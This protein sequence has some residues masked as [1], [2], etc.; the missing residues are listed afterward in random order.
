MSKASPA[1]QAVAP[2]IVLSRDG[3]LAFVKNS[4]CACT[5]ITKAIHHYDT[6]AQFDG[7][8]HR[9][10]KHLRQGYRSWNDIRDALQSNQPYVFSFVRDPEARAVSAYV[11]FVVKA[12]NPSRRFHQAT[13]LEFGLTRDVDLSQGFDRFL[14]MIA[15]QL[16]E[17]PIRTDRHW[18]LQKDN[19]GLGWISYD[20]IGR[21]EHLAQDFQQVRNALGVP[22]ERFEL[23]VSNRTGSSELFNITKD[24]RRRVQDIYAADYTT[25]AETFEVGP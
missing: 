16:S 19:L 25:F 14:D 5:S 11:D 22:T 10:G 15:S 9:E 20:F 23:S 4:K 6:G 17:D 21:V 13:F 24:Q 7:N 12:T 2:F 18:R 3:R 1:V 8:I